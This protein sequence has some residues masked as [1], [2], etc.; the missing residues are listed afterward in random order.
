[1]SYIKQILGATSHKTTVVRP[2]SSY[3][4]DHPSQTKK[5]C[6]TLLE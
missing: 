1:M 2:P 6:V 4:E 5:T 3:L